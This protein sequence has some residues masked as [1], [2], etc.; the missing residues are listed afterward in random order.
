MAH[1]CV[2]SALV[3]C[4]GLFGSCSLL[5]EVEVVDGVVLLQLGH[6]PNCDADL[7][8][9]YL[10]FGAHLKLVCHWKY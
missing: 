9:E 7:T 3:H 2:A 6:Q 1:V 4:V 10:L 8:I 5:Q